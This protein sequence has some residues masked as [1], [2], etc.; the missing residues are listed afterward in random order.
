[1][2]ESVLVSVIIPCYNRERYI[3]DAIDSVLTQTYDNIEII[4]IDDGSQDRSAE[5]VKS[6]GEDVKYIYQDNSGV[7]S[8]RN[9][10]I[11]HA[12]G[13]FLIFLDS[14]DWI[15]NDLIEK[16]IDTFKKWPV[17]DICCS[18]NLYVKENGSLSDLSKS[19]WPDTPSTPIELFLLKAPPF[20]AC[21]MY[22]A[23]TVK[24][25]GGFDET[26]K[27]FADSSLRISIVLNGGKV[28]RTEGGHAIYRPVENS[29]T[30]SG[31]KVYKFGVILIHK[32]LKEDF[33]KQIEV[34]NLIKERLIRHRFRY[35]YYNCSYH[36]S[37][38]PLSI[39]KLIY[40]ILKVVKVDF[41]FF[42]F[43]FFQKPWKIKED[44]IF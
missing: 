5:V 41:G 16:Q 9:N 27:A 6:Y 19:N 35:W 36:L 31:L 13:E 21:E 38:K 40:N 39:M 14:D 10:G 18:D 20:P 8:A 25:Y 26:M 3:K 17:I 29:I 42:Y 34:K 43:L 1:M 37:L 24:K 44:R 2:E 4:V 12:S 33:S 28:V 30:K 32:L 22:R 11:N 15:S 23:T 7:S